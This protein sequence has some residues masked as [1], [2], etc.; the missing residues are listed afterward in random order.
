MS[1][2]NR[3]FKA[4]FTIADLRANRNH[5]EVFTTACGRRES[6]QHFV[7]KLLS[8]CLFSHNES[9]ILNT[10]HSDSEPDVSI[11]ALDDHY[12]TWLAVD[13]PD[14]V[15]LN[16][17]AKRVDELWVVT[18][19]NHEWLQEYEHQLEL[20]NNSHLIAFDGN[21]IEQL[22]SHLTK[23]LQWDVTIDQQTVSVSDK[24]NF[25]QTNEL[26]WH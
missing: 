1:D 3:V 4:N 24:E 17:I 15:Q 9:A 8:Y 5:K 21:F 26:V 20:I 18:T 10:S 12:Q 7:L 19:L 11:K 22:A 14:I 23:N 6:Y 16:K 25:Y 2:K 13:Q